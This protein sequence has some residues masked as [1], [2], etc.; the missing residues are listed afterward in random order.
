MVAGT[1]G[2]AWLLSTELTLFDAQT[3]TATVVESGV[4]YAYGIAPDGNGGVWLSDSKGLTH[5]DSGG[6]SAITYM[7]AQIGTIPQVGARA[8]RVCFTGSFRVNVDTQFG[9]GGIAC[10]TP[11][12]DFI[13]AFTDRFSP[14][15]S[16]IARDGTDMWLVEGGRA[17][18]VDA[19]DSIRRYLYSSLPTGPTNA[20][21][22][23]DHAVW[24]AG[25]GL[26]ERFYGSGA[27]Q[28]YRITYPGNGPF[29][30]AADGHDGVV[31]T[32]G[33]GVGDISVDGDGAEHLHFYDTGPQSS[34]EGV[35]AASDGTI[36]CTDTRGWLVRVSNDSTVKRY[37]V[38]TSPSEPFGIARGPDGA[39]WF[40]EFFG[41]KIGRL[42]PK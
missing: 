20:A 28:R 18:R 33:H 30:L 17:T 19:T 12:L 35:V 2:R 39:I 25:A 36:W 41:A 13:T 24:M 1:R 10:L 5:V 29:G 22:S 3:S 34:P 23:S 6:T 21:V 32:I 4:G 31:F 15:I 38:P 16:G 14:G 42:D 26:V 11:S 27:S 8:D 37:R 9:E 7:I 40:T